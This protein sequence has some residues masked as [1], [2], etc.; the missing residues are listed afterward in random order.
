MQKALGLGQ[1]VLG[2]FLLSLGVT[3]NGALDTL[4]PQAYGQK[5]LRLCRVY[6][7]RQLYMTT[8]VFIALAIPLVL[9]KPALIGIGQSEE[10]AGLASIYVLACIPG[11]LF[12]SW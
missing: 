9:V 5:D 10:V 3:F 2:I 1:L 8:Y 12:Y 6:L 7:N 4:I 11:V